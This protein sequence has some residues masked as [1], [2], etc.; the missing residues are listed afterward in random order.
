M[1]TYTN[2]LLNPASI[3]ATV[4]STAILT[5]A[6]FQSNTLA[7]PGDFFYSKYSAFGAELDSSPPMTQCPRCD[8]TVSF[9]VYETINNWQAELGLAP[10]T[11]LGNTDGTEQYVLLYQVVNTDTIPPE[12]SGAELADFFLA[13]EQGKEPYFGSNPYKSAGYIQDTVFNSA[14]FA[15]TPLDAPSDWTVSSDLTFNGFKTLTSAV[16]PA[17]IIYGQIADDEVAVRGG[18]TPTN[19]ITFSFNPLIPI[20]DSDPNA[21]GG[22]GTSSLLFLTAD[23]GWFQQNVNPNQKI[24]FSF[25][26]GR[27]ESIHPNGQPANGTSGDVVGVKVVNVPEPGTIF[28]LLAFGFLGLIT[29][30]KKHQM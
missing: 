14:S 11:L 15:T 7:A 3:G 10:T 18:P 23:E 21:P 28:G 22:R 17:T 26:W 30:S 6:G 29:K 24:A 27:T 2:K 8:S 1:N 25:P 9:T 13:V 5:L 4:M 20:T 12:P 19:G 16:E